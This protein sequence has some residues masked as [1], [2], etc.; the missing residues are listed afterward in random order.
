MINRPFRI[1]RSFTHQTR[2][3]LIFF[4]QSLYDYDPLFTCMSPAIMGSV[5][6]NHSSPDGCQICNPNK[7]KQQTNSLTRTHVSCCPQLLPLPLQLLQHTLS[8]CCCCRLPAAHLST[9]STSSSLNRKRQY[10]SQDSYNFFLLSTS[11]RAQFSST[12]LSCCAAYHCRISI[13]SL[14]GSSNSFRI[15]TMMDRINR[16]KPELAR[17]RRPIPFGQCGSCVKCAITQ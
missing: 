5:I 9:A 11:V 17:S 12:C 1:T 10:Y 15:M 2:N 3:A 8:C 16:E 7:T 6:V 4:C 13:C 14:T